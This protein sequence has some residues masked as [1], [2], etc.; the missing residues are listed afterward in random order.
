MYK[1][2]DN[3]GGSVVG[4]RI[5]IKGVPMPHCISPCHHGTSLY[6]S[7]LTLTDMPSSLSSV[8]M[9]ACKY[10]CLSVLLSVSSKKL[11]SGRGSGLAP[12]GTWERRSGLR[13][14]THVCV[15]CTHTRFLLVLGPLD[16]FLLFL[17]VTPRS[18]SVNRW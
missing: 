2:V 7:V 5:E 13:Q 10:V 11:L 3:C 8:H 1:E 15:T 6:P 18:S 17:T 16:Q 9:S 4:G 12:A 14:V